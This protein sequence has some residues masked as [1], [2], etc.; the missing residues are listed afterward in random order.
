VW[1]FYQLVMTQ[2]PR[3]ASQPD[4][5][6]TPANTFP[7]TNA[8]S[9]FAN[10]TMETFDQAN[11]RTGCMACH[12]L[13]RLPTDFVWTLNDHAFPPNVASFLMRNTAVRELQTLLRSTAPK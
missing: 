2:W 5:P 10:V 4:K 8:T 7:G 6:G 11:T 1:Q 3:A 13:T 12:N 9:A